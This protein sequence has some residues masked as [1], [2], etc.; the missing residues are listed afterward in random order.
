MAPLL[1]NM[2]STCSLNL[3]SIILSGPIFSQQKYIRKKLS[4]NCVNICVCV[5]Y[6]SKLFIIYIRNVLK[7][8]RAL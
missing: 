8:T 3:E 7:E 5:K 1:K 4:I 2:M 6:M